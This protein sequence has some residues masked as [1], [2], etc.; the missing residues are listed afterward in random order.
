M[1]HL[2]PKFH[3]NREE[4]S[5]DSRYFSSSPIH[6]RPTTTPPSSSISL[7]QHFSDFLLVKVN[8]RL[9]IHSLRFNFQIFSRELL[10]LWDENRGTAWMWRLPRLIQLLDSIYCHFLAKMWEVWVR[11]NALSVFSHSWFMFSWSNFC[12][13]SYLLE[14]SANA[15][16]Y[17]VP[18]LDVGEELVSWKGICIIRIHVLDPLAG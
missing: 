17:Q 5:H 13:W 8:F 12:V 3:E 4:R 14:Y 9:V 15:F 2:C 6:R 7:R 10:F 18:N 16:A 1:G 11:W